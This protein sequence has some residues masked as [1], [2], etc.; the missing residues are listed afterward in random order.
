[1]PPL[2][3]HLPEFAKCLPWIA[4]MHIDIGGQLAVHAEDY[5]SPKELAHFH[6]FKHLKRRHE[7]FTARLICKLL[8][9]RYLS[10]THLANSNFVW[11]PTIQKFGCN[12][13]ATVLPI[14]YRSIEVLPPNLSLKGASQLFWQGNILSTIYLSISHAGGWA[15]ASLSSSGPVGLDVEE[16]ISHRPDFYESYFSTQETLWVQQQIKDDLSISQLYTL[17]WTLKE[18]YLKTSISPINNICDFANL[19][20]KI[21]ASLFTVSKH[22]PEIEFNPQLHILKLQF[23]YAKSTFVPYAAFSIM[24]NL[25]LSMVAFEL[26]THLEDIFKVLRE[27]N[28]L[29]HKQNYLNRLTQN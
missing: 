6:Q 3:T 14:V 17:L 11:P 25:I 18:S 8:F 22:L 21:D 19:E 26:N 10:N 12:D 20:L 15:I 28:S 16:P 7:W 4:A 29:I 13:I 27:D 24:P 1:M 5:L 2:T 9:S 23:S